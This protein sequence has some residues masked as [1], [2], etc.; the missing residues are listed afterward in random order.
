MC[1]HLPCC[2]GRRITAEFSKRNSPDDIRPVI[3][4]S[5]EAVCS[6]CGQL[7]IVHDKCYRFAEAVTEIE[8]EN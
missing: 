5:E 3:S 2:T 4:T 8:K 7:L 1:K 6:K